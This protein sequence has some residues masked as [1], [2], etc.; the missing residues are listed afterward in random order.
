MYNLIDG[1]E[2]SKQMRIEIKKE[3]EKL[4]GTPKLVVVLVGEDP[5]SQVYVSSK[6]KYAGRVGM[7]SEVIKL[8]ETTSEDELLSIVD[9]LNNDVTVNG[10]LVQF[11]VPKHISQD[12]I[13]NKIAPQKDVDGLTQVSIG[14]LVAGIDGLTP[15]TPAGVIKMIKSTGI[16]ISGKNAVIVGRSLLVGKPVAMMLLKEN[17]TVTMCHSRTNDLKAEVS[18]ADIVVAAVGIPNFIKGDMIKDGAVVIDVGINRVEK[19]LVG[20]VDF[21]T[22][23]E[24]ASYITPVP[25]G[26][27][28]MTIAMLLQNTLTA[29]KAQNNK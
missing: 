12:K 15:C 16:E 9:K 21:E 5:A 22:A 17:A 11:P 4:E 18:R 7:A 23:K 1:K 14:K 26:V 24:K 25:G 2:L 6:E 8:P 20:D 10:I 3:I 19:K 13:M 28:P 27:G 29:Y